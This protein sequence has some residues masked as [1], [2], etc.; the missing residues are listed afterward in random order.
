ME[1]I[2]KVFLTYGWW[3]ILGIVICI[4][5]WWFGKWAIKKM[6]TNV[7]SGLEE[8]GKN[9]TTEISNQNKEL[10]T[11]IMQQHDKLINYMINNKADEAK[12]HDA[13]LDDRMKLTEDIKNALKEIGLTHHAER[14]FIVEFH[15]SY[16]NLS[17]TPF[18]KFSCTYEWVDKNIMPLQIAVKDLQFSILSTVVQKVYHSKSQQIAY[19][20]IEEFINDCPAL[21]PYFKDYPAKTMVCTAMYDRNNRM[22][23]GLILEWAEKPEDINFN[24]LHIQ[25]AEL[26]SM[27]NLRYK[28]L[29]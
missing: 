26:T 9:L 19:Y 13:M 1:T 18:A 7:T 23:G 14:V 24:Q 6:A 2:F 4:G 28:Y 15:N 25:A 10:V 29:K 16:Q 12:N 20:D 3:G 17:G 22:I 8:V 11:T 27:I 21:A 5:L